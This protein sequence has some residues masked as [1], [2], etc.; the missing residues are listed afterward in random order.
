MPREI[1]VVAYTNAET[2]GG[3]ERCLATIL[4]GLPASFRVT[5]VAT[6]AAVAET[7]AGGCRRGDRTRAAGTA[8]LG[9]TSGGGPQ[10][11][12]AAAR[13]PP[14]RRSICRRR[15][16][17]CM[18]RLAALLVPRLQVVAIEHLPLPS[19]SR[20]AHWLKRVTSR[21]LAAHV[22]VS[23]HTAEAIAAEAA[24]RARE[25]ARRAKRRLRAGGR[26]QS[27][28]D[29]RGRSSAD[30]GA[31][32][33]RKVSMSSSTP[34]QRCP[35]S[36][37]WSPARVRSGMRSCSVHAIAR[38]RI[39]SRSSPGRPTSDR[40]CAR[41][42]SS[43]CRPD[44]RGCRSCCSRRWPPATPA[45]AADVGAVSEAVVSGESGLLVPPDDAPALAAGIWT[46]PRRQG[47]AGAAWRP[48]AGSV[49]VPVHGGADA[50]V[51][52][53][54]LHAAGSMTAFADPRFLLPTPPRS[55]VVLP[56]AEA[57][58]PLLERAGIDTTSGPPV[59]VAI[60]G[61]E[62]AAGADR[63]VSRRDRRGR[64]SPRTA[65]RA[66]GTSCSAAGTGPPCSCRATAAT[67]C[68]MRSRPGRRLGRG[69]AC[70]AA[71]LVGRMPRLALRLARWPVVTIAT[72]DASPPYVVAAALEL[73]ELE[74]PVDWLLVCGQSD[75]LGRAAFLLFPRGR[76]ATALDREVRSSSLVLRPDR[77][78]RAC[79]GSRGGR[80][81]VWLPPTRRASSAGSRWAGWPPRSRPRRAGR[82]LSAVL[83]LGR[84]PG[85]EA[86]DRR[87][88]G[89][90]DRPRRRR[91]AP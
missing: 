45:V 70:S 13:S 60:T 34:S 53:R 31:S 55:A 52:R 40:S 39:A 19:R 11:P 27:S 20:G 67:S 65:T 59:D 58:L 74:S 87:R 10:A 77:S 21:R 51:L 61:P 8:I 36:R 29:C 57:W 84:L 66:G 12:P 6:D 72:R 33:G 63:R 76:A 25:D 54:P 86:E 88:G 48:G 2:V 35:A 80:G 32:T 81:R 7:V 85:G 64:R 17:A 78:R 1:R 22:A 79:A 14:V 9:R 41:S 89:G 49:A 26:H 91:D 38:W 18:P 46:T 44:T 42:T 75:D 82:R 47:I 3:A 50:A 62:P 69:R 16:P 28:S 4:A 43:C 15:T 90:L 68:P 30:W 37:R 56:G 24:T 23:A 83:A 5:V 73:L 71:Y